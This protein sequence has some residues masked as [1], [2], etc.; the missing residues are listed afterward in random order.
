[1][2]FIDC[3]LV[4]SHFSSYWSTINQGKPQFLVENAHLR[5]LPHAVLPQTNSQTALIA[6]G[7]R[8]FLPFK[9]YFFN[10]CLRIFHEG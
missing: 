2:D 10:S 9:C 6:D 7:Q 5:T 1:M 8:V 3:S 4:C